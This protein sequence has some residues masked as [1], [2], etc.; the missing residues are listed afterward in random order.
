MFSL[1]LFRASSRPVFF[2]PWPRCLLAFVRRFLPPPRREPPP[3]STV[4]FL[5]SFTSIQSPSTRYFS[6]HDLHILVVFY[7]PVLSSFL[8]RP[9]PPT[10]AWT[11]ASSPSSGFHRRLVSFGASKYPYFLSDPRKP[12]SEQKPARNL[13]QLARRQHSQLLIFANGGGTAPSAPSSR[14]LDWFRRSYLIYRAAIDHALEGLPRK[15]RFKNAKTPRFPRSKSPRSFALPSL[16]SVLQCLT[17]Q[18]P[19]IREWQT[20]STPGDRSLFPLFRERAIRGSLERGARFLYISPALRIWFDSFDVE[21]VRKPSEVEK[22]FVDAGRNVNDVVRLRGSA[23]KF[24]T[25]FN[26]SGSVCHLSGCLSSQRQSTRVDLLHDL[27]YRVTVTKI[28]R[29]A[30]RQSL[31][32]GSLP[33]SATGAFP[34]SRSRGH[35][36]PL[37]GVR[38]SPWQARFE[39]MNLNLAR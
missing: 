20:Q 10:N 36:T 22:S 2:P 15:S 28:R 5:H 32:G 35:V 33:I 7:L 13:L 31:W 23:E 17:F 30:P 19:R 27:T 18:L 29:L 9:C 37:I 24:S 39:L 16:A 26:S 4:R 14:S 34:E 6:F 1:P 12:S 8:R 3:R 38:N 25:L 21:D 11:P